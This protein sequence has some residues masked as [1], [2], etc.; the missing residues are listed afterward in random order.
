MYQLINELG[1]LLPLLLFLVSITLYFQSLIEQPTNALSLNSD[2]SRTERRNVVQTYASMPLDR[3]VP[4]YCRTGLEAE[5]KQLIAQELKNRGWQ[6]RTLNTG[7]TVLVEP[8]T[9]GLN[10][11]E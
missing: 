3:L 4:L 2:V 11:Q 5:S 10:D 1:I 8:Q 9:L 7:R 6:E